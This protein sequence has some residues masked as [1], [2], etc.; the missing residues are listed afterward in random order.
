[1]EV[2]G[3]NGF[4]PEEVWLWYPSNRRLA[5]E[6]V[7]TLWKRG[8]SLPRRESNPFLDRQPSPLNHFTYWDISAHI[9]KEE[10]TLKIVGKY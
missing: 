6:A 10:D 1:V 3:S 8:K 2:T 7:W 4:L 5:L 9:S